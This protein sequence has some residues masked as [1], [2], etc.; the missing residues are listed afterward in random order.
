MNQ[1]KQQVARQFDLPLVNNR[2]R[3]P[4]ARI[5]YDLAQGAHSGH[6]D[7]E[8][9]TAAYRPGH[10]R[11]KVQ[12]GFHLYASACDR[13]RLIARLE[14]DHPLRQGIVEL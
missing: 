4:D 9:L 1:I 14:N 7:I 6:Q 11:S 2:I 3:I 10:L 12:A 13:N 8:V 5:D